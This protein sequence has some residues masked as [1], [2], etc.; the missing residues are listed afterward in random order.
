MLPTPNGVKRQVAVTV[1]PYACAETGH[2]ICT[3]RWLPAKMEKL[4]LA[5]T[6]LLAA[7]L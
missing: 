3:P 5:K 4:Q 1:A 6:C 7:L 2:L